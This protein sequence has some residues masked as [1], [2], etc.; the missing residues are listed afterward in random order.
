MTIKEKALHW[1]GETIKEGKNVVFGADIPDQ[2]QRSFLVKQKF[3][4]NIAR[5][6]WLLKRPEDDAK[7]VFSLVYWKIIQT[8]LSRYTWSVSGLSAVI[9]L[10]G[11][12][13]AQKE[14]TVNTKEKTNWK[15]Q[16]ID[17]FSVSLHYEPNFD[18]R[19]IK[20]TKITN[21]EIP[22]AI[23][24][25]VFID[26]NNIDLL[27]TRNFIAGTDF[28]L[29]KLDALYSK[30]P[31][32]IVFKRLIDMSKSVD[33]LDLVA[34]LERIIDTYTHY[35]VG[36]KE[37]INVKLATQ[38]PLALKPPWIIR[39]EQ[40]IEK[41]EEVLE[42][43]LKSKVDPLKKYSLDKLLKQAK[44][45]KKYDTYHSTS[46]EGYQI[47]P[48]EVNALLSGEIP[49]EVK[50]R[51]D[52]Y[53]EKIKNRMAI[54]GYSGAFDFILNKA[55]D[56]FK[57][58]TVSQK[59]IK[60]SYY[61]L[62]KPS[63]DAEIVDSWLLADYRN[64]PVFIRGASY[65]PP[66]YEKL[67][68]LM[69]SFEIIINKIKNPVIKAILAHYLFVTIHP[70]SDGNGRTAR[71]L[72]NYVLLASGYSWITIRTDQRIEYF[73]ALQKAQTDNDII[74]FGKF[75]VEMLKAVD[76]K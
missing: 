61:Q 13:G 35:S 69:E 39:Q 65:V 31:K 30:T 51:G 75:I 49:K 36:K 32:P 68:E 25:K 71:L 27:E 28:D 53:F 15:L 4:V 54:L 6:Y 55:K 17:D 62:F 7:E 66:A 19:L 74:A 50:E 5:G 47:T 23:S 11:G 18:D 26:I 43:K 60:D 1:W 57:H 3:I 73:T 21:R 64:I 38:K 56:D 33:R 41:F 76:K 52:A 72:M 63:A 8:V 44:E 58:P 59:L 20:Q 46:L 10:N 24:E 34:G 70:Y 12:Q 45:H 2:R 42:E 22:V 29:R 9:I 67:P 48:E 14:L 40:Q 16:L 37:G